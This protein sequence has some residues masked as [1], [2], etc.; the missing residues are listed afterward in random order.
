MKENERREG[1]RRDAGTSVIR[2]IGKGGR[3]NG[4]RERK[5]DEEKEGRKENERGRD[6][7]RGVMGRR[8]GGG[9]GYK[10]KLRGNEKRKH[11]K[12]E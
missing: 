10:E 4:R 9:L 8:G 6:A 1:G 2:G 11:R 12:L 7:G 5:G 3:R